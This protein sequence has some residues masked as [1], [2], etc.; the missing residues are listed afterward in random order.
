MAKGIVTRKGKP[1]GN[2]SQFILRGNLVQDNSQVLCLVSQGPMATIPN[3]DSGTKR[4]YALP[5]L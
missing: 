4:N 3:Q 2:Y 1:V 5:V